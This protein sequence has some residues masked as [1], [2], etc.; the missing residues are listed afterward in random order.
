MWDDQVV[1]R[2][3]NL[4]YEFGWVLDLI[5]PNFL[6]SQTKYSKYGVGLDL[7]ESPNLKIKFDYSRSFNIGKNLNK[8][9]YK[10]F[11]HSKNH[12]VMLTVQGRFDYF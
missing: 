4:N 6:T 11:L 7:Y 9:F 3:Y 8:E 2:A 1:R 12:E 5:R 10:G